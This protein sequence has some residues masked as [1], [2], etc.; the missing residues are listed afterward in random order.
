MARIRNERS[1]S[2]VRGALKRTPPAPAKDEEDEHH[3][4]YAGLSE[5]GRHEQAAADLRAAWFDATQGFLRMGRIVL[6]AAYDGE[7][8]EALADAAD[9]NPRFQRLVRSLGTLDGG[10]SARV[11]SVARRVVACA[12]AVR[13]PFWKVAPY[14]HKE[15]LV[16]LKEPEKM[17][18]GAKHVVELSWT[19]AQTEKWVDAQRA[20]AKTPKVKRGRTAGSS[21]KAAE[22][23]AAAAEPE[24]LDRIAA[25]YEKMSASERRRYREAL[26]KAADALQRLRRRLG[27]SDR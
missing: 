27:R 17:A 10:P 12:R 20:E 16:R 11:L 23:L 14:S 19:L 4:P 8:S 2:D 9:E 25:E 6:L 1:Q 15:I 22:T 13:S 5:E 24:S 3:N 7:T 21:R 18:E 26:E